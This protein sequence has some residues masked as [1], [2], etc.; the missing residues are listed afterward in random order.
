MRRAAV[1][2][3]CT[4]AA[5]CARAD[6]GGWTSL[7][8]DTGVYL[9][10]VCA[11]DATH[12]FT[13]GYVLEGSGMST[14]PLT[15]VFASDDGGQSFTDISNS[16]ANVGSL[17]AWTTSVAFVDP[18]HGFVAIGQSIQRTSD[19]GATWKPA[20]AGFPV[21][22]M[23]F[24]DATTGLAVGD[25]GRIARTTDGGATWKA[26]TSPVTTDLWHV[27]VVSA[28]LAFAAGYDVDSDTG[29]PSNAVLL[30]ST[31]GGL[32]W[33]EGAGIA[34]QGISSIFFLCDG[35]TGYVA[36]W[37]QADDSSTF[38]AS[39]YATTDGGQTLTDLQLPEKVGTISAFGS[40]DLDT[41][42]ILAQWWDD[43]QHGHLGALGFLGHETQQQSSSGGGGG[44]STTMSSNLWKVADYVTSD[45]GASWTKS[46]LGT[47]HVTISYSGMSG[48]DGSFQAGT[49]RDFDNGWLVGADGVVWGYRRS[50]GGDADC[51]EGYR[52]SQGTCSDASS[53]TCPTGGGGTEGDGG[54]TGGGT[55]P[56][57]A[58]GGAGLVEVKDGCDC[59]GAG[60]LSVLWL[61]GLVL[62]RRR[63]EPGP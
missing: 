36:A 7:G 60:A 54:S 61:M 22:A 42:E 10:G 39:L 29:V 32:T 34:D 11:P 14:K 23:A 37:R 8:S 30:S 62:R 44:S 17:Q 52:C 38:D 19:G 25:G 26:V 21:E 45:G 24:L 1:F 59:N 41:G 12:V 63:G 31:D 48:G 55:T 40:S 18:T 53:T 16:L 47:V 3:V 20:A 56:K 9:V 15:R 49:L 33:T 5:V 2:A 4:L 57:K 58:D 50:C 43:A 46:D 6:T 35:K 51:Q 27:Q 28:K 13:A